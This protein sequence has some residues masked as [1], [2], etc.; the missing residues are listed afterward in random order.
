MCCVYAWGVCVCQWTCVLTVMCL[1]LFVALAVNHGTVSCQT[2]E[3]LCEN[4]M[5]IL[6]L[7]RLVVLLCRMSRC[8]TFQF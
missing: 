4:N 8:V 2:S 1:L 6:K 7:L 5:H 3:T